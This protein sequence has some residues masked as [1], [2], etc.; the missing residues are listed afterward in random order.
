MIALRLTV[1]M[2]CWRK[3]MAREY[4]ES[5]E[6]PPPSTVYGALLSLVGETERERHA[7]CRLTAGLL[8][9]GGKGMALRT[10]W[11][12]K[13]KDAPQGTG[14]N[15]RPDFQELIVQ[16][17]LMVWLESSAERPH[18]P[19]LEA[20]V[21]AALKEP[22]GIARFGGWSLGESTHLINDCWLVDL[23]PPSVCDV[24]V[25]DETGD[26]S[27]PV[28]V[29]H[30]GTAGTKS[31]VGRLLPLREAPSLQQLAAVQP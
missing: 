26:L 1:P 31:V 12:I 6:V 5:E 21:G 16:S 19:S 18:G 10:L 4:L 14:A 25:V 20:R 17:D 7:G 9:Q 2:A 27:L 30:V 23:A 24:F 13:E 11:R 28:W 29:D 22:G 15:A 3:G 8:S